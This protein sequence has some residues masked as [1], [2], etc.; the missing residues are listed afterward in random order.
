MYS[1]RLVF[2]QVMDHLPYKPFTRIIDKYSGDY[3]IKHFSCKNQFY[4][5]A[6]GQLTYRNSLR[7][8]VSCLRANS[9]KLYHMGIRGSVSR[10]N[11]SNAN[12]TRDWRI[13]EELAYTLIDTARKL[14]SEDK[15]CDEINEPVY[16]LDSTTISMSLSLFPWAEFRKSKGGIKLHT[17]LELPSSIPTFIDITA[18]KPHDVNI[19]DKI[20]L[21]P[22]AYYVMDMGYMDF[23]RL[24]KIT[25]RGAFFVTRAKRN[26]FL[27]RRY[28]LPRDKTQKCILSDQIVFAG[29]ESSYSKYPAVLRR[30]RYRD[31]EENK[32]YVFLTNNFDLDALT[33]AALYKG[34]W[35]VELFFKWIKQHLKIQRFF[36]HNLN[37]V[38]TQIWIGVSVYVLVAIIRKRLNLEQLTLYNIL[39][40]LSVSSL[41]YD[42]LQQLLT[43]NMVQANVY[44]NPNQ[45]QLFDL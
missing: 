9:N 12:M 22:G 15:F 38:K 32:V 35:Q 11:L 8:I 10:N 41:C 34:R 14:Y 28:S 45:L 37:A 2:S 26:V 20:I 4:C 7:D 18:A 23:A 30:I 27:K 21:E 31:P 42:S 19:L 39:Q 16:A 33:I 29:K 36:G 17:L 6:F 13:Y 40:I 24:Y 1:G 25:K 44:N 5:M 43:E 3:K